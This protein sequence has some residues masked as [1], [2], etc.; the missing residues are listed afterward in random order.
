MRESC[1]NLCVYAT[2]EGDDVV[3]TQRSLSNKKSRDFL[4][5]VWLN[6]FINSTACLDLKKTHGT[7]GLA[8]ELNLE[9]TFC[10]RSFSQLKRR[11]ELFS[12]CMC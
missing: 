10:E 11:V 12:N 7:S 5:E 9:G 8:L 6:I 4:H 2:S 1:G 3:A